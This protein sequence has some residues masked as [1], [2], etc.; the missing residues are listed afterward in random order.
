MEPLPTENMAKSKA[1]LVK[2]AKEIIAES[3]GRICG[4]CFHLFGNRC[5]RPSALP[6]LTVTVYRGSAVA[7]AMWEK[8]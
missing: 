4:D 1:K 3:K 5:V 2:A 8:R 7:C 6:E